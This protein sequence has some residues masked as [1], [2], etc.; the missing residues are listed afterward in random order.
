MDVVDGLPRHVELATV[1]IG[2]A[3]GALGGVALGTIAGPIGMV[4]GGILGAVAGAGCGDAVGKIQEHRSLHDDQIDE[5]M[6]V[7]DGN[8]GTAAW[9]QP[10][11]RIGAYSAA[12]AGIT[13]TSVDSAP[14]EGPMPMAD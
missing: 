2:A 6:G 4:I 12:S 1:G 8:L 3:V 13:S 11:A 7:I 10:P 9:D 14:A 5:V